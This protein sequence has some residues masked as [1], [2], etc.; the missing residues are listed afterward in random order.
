MSQRACREA[1]APPSPQASPS[2][3]SPSAPR[4]DLLIDTH[5]V[6]CKYTAQLENELRP[7]ASELGPGEGCSC[8]ECGRV[9]SSPSQLQRHCVSHSTLKPFT[10][11]AC[12]LAFKRSSDLARHR[13]PALDPPRRARADRPHACSPCPRRFQDD[14]A[15]AQ[16]ARLH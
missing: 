12:S 3:A 6:P 14:T 5:G 2:S 16:H 15:L 11:I 4:H 10:C 8:P 1:I 13:R 9:C 7:P